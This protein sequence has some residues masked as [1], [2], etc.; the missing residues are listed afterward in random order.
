M[1]LCFVLQCVDCD[2]LRW[3]DRDGIFFCLL[4]NWVIKD[5]Y[6]KR[7]LEILA[8]M[9]GNWLPGF[10]NRNWGNIFILSVRKVVFWVS[11]IF[12][13]IFPQLPLQRHSLNK[14]DIC[15]IPSF[16]SSLNDSSVA[17]DWSPELKSFPCPP[18]SPL[19]WNLVA[20]CRRPVVK[21][22]SYPW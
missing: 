21:P 20:S 4:F 5:I 15:H 2:R 14:C 8:K 12:V 16:R 13:C 17:A 10:R 19:W 22:V 18:T 7:T 11:V 9:G 1:V 6:C 3:N